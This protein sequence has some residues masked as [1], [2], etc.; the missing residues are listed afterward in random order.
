MEG[1][2]ETKTT[3]KVRVERRLTFVSMATELVLFAPS[4]ESFMKIA[5]KAKCQH[6]S[7][8]YH[9]RLCTADLLRRG[10]D[11][12]MQTLRIIKQVLSISIALAP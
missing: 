1:G 5:L 7:Y 12:E 9:Y 11:S 3:L 10:T 4:P 2:D 6:N 8:Y